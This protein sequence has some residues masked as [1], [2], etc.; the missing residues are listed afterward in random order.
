[1]VEF[2]RGQFIPHN[3]EGNQQ[4]NDQK[5]DLF[6]YAPPDFN[7]RSLREQ[8]VVAKPHGHP[9]QIFIGPIDDIFTVAKG[10]DLLDTLG[11]EELRKLSVLVIFTTGENGYGRWKDGRPIDD[12]IIQSFG[13]AEKIQSTKYSKRIGNRGIWADVRN[14]VFTTYDYQKYREISPLV[15]SVIFASNAIH[16]WV[17]HLQATTSLPVNSLWAERAAFAKQGEFLQKALNSNQFNSAEETKIAAALKDLATWSFNYRNG[18][19]FENHL[20]SKHA[21]SDGSP[22]RKQSLH[23]EDFIFGY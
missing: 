1:M 20:I 19:G 15:A 21:N 14:P 17:H 10:Y 6:I 8:V 12:E 9:E 3:L 11:Y 4:I 7:N 23:Q 16:E 22:L 13:I 2:T 5:S 18:K